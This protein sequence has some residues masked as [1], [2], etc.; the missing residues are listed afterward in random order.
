MLIDIIYAIVL[1][2]AFIHGYRKGLIHS[3]VSLIAIIIGIM[4]AVYLSEIA[5]T[6]INRWFNISSKYL[7]IISFVLVFIVIYLLF[8]MI[9][10][11]LEGFFKLLKLNFINQL[12][13]ALIWCVVWTML[14]STILF[15][16]NNMNLFSD[17][18]KKKSTIKID[19]IIYINNDLLELT[20][21]YYFKGTYDKKSKK[22]IVK[23]LKQ[24]A[25]QHL[26]T[27]GN[28]LFKW[29]EEVV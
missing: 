19:T 27:L 24:S 21:N 22:E 29:R 26:R 2:L 10:R 1:I 9:E 16:F 23:E 11:A 14:Y 4:A 28:T 5:S 17:E 13:G 15:Y 7:P 12:A 3:I 20:M 8:R 25:F 6:Y 18:L